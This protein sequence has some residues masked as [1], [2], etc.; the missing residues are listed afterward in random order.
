MYKYN[1]IILNYLHYLQEDQIILK[2]KSYLI[3]FH[4]F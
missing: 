3:D 2:L 1:N 4:L